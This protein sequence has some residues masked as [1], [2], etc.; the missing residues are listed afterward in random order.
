MLNDLAS[1]R[2]MTR[3]KQLSNGMSYLAVNSSKLSSW[4]PSDS[5]RLEV[6][7]LLTDPEVAI[8]A[9]TA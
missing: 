4:C 3:R 6:L 9:G 7:K 2:S 5:F 8:R 1:G